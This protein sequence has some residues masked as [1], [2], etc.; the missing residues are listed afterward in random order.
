MIKSFAKDILKYSPSKI[1]PGL[2]GVLIIPAF[3]RLFEPDE[4][5]QYVLVISSIAVLSIIAIDWINT[6]VVR[7]Y[8]GYEKKVQLKLFNGTIIRLT[9]LSIIGLSTISLV[10][11]YFFKS[12]F[13]SSLYYYLN[14]GL[15]I[16]G[17]GAVFNVMLEM[18]VVKR[19]P[20]LYSLASIWR[21]C[22]CIL[23]GICVVAFSRLSVDGLLWGIFIGI[24]I[25]LPILFRLTFKKLN[26]KLYSKELRINIVS[27]GFPLVATNLAA[28]ILALSDRYMIEYFRGS[29]E[30][31]FYSISYSLAD[32]S[33]QLI[34]SLMI[35][36][37]APIAM[38]LWATKGIDATSLFVRDLTKYYMII[39][40]P[41]AVGLSLLAKPIL[42]LLAT[43]SFYE[44][45]KIMPLVAASIFLFGLQRNFQLGLLFYKKT[46][47]IMYILLISA[48]INIILNIYFIP[49]YGFI[50]AGYTTLFSY[51]IFA[52]LIIFI[53][54]RYFI[55]QFPFKTLFTTLVSVVVMS[56][57]VLYTIGLNLESATE[58]ILISIILGIIIYFISLLIMKEINKN[59]IKNILRLF[60]RN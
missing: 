18:L 58:T 2:F 44:G 20:T 16:F 17:V 41:A 23:I 32:R 12:Y 29:H 48:L 45:Y 5:G 35:L 15:L 28:W 7:F 1:L 38:K 47:L 33:I 52:V 9:G 6:S 46:K 11:L 49:K 13:N 51:A 60:K 43:Q 4:Y 10:V 21:Q 57:V 39:T 42:Q 54:R 14:I 8:A 3:T 26:L 22:G 53:S 30:V 34:V 31:G 56:I 24:L 25:T 37:S 36:S 50:A 55:F 59:T 40:L 27:Y 19:N